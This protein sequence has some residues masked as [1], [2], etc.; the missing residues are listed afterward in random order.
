MIRKEAWKYLIADEAY[1]SR[2]RQQLFR[3]QI[4]DLDFA[5]EVLRYHGHNPEQSRPAGYLKKDLYGDLKITTQW[6]DANKDLAQK[7]Q[8]L[9]TRMGEAA[10]RFDFWR[11]VSEQPP[12]FVRQYLPY[13]YIE[14]STPARSTAHHFRF[15]TMSGQYALYPVPVTEDNPDSFTRE[16]KPE[17]EEEYNRGVESAIRFV[18]KLLEG[19]ESLQEKWR[20]S[21]QDDS[22]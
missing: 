4:S 14:D 16:E 1:L 12:E 10:Y 8:D 21:T 7:I 3:G 22:P 5:K 18:G 11:W 6:L 17:S 13:S 9:A 2:L 19:I 15:M 20:E